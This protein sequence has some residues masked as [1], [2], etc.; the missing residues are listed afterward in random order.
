MAVCPVENIPTE[1]LMSSW[2]AEQPAWFWLSVATV[3]VCIGIWVGTVSTGLKTTRGALTEIRS[4]IRD[5]RHDVAS[6]L[7]GLLPDRSLLTNDSPLR[8]TALG[9]KIARQIG[10]EEV[11]TQMARHVRPRVIGKSEYEVQEECFSYLRDQYRPQHN[12]EERI[13]KSAYDH[14]LSRGQVIDVL[15]VMLRDELLKQGVSS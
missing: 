2:L 1:G 3:L 13:L 9:E 4:D 15:A 8:V 10:A 6:L 12:V 5:I 11:V 7:R 14:G